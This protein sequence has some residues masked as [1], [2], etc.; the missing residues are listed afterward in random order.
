[1]SRYEL[2]GV[3]CAKA[4]RLSLALVESL[5]ADLRLAM[6]KGEAVDCLA[7]VTEVLQTIEERMKH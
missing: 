7:K 5:Q 1:M 6:E 2:P 4:L 3:Q